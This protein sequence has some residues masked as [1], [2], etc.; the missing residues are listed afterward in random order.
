MGLPDKNESQQNWALFL[1]RDGVINERLAGDY[2]KDILQFRFIDGALEALSFLS[3]I[4]QKI[5]I[6]SNQ[7]GIGKGIMT[8]RE[9]E[10]VHLFM[11]EKIN[12]SGGRIDAIYYCPALES[13]NHPDRK[14]GI[15]MAMKAQQDFTEIE[16]SKSYMVGDSMSD[17]DFG[18]AL[19]MK[20][21]FVNGSESDIKKSKADLFF[22]SLAEFA[23]YVEIYKNSL[24]L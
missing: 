15:G 11:V 8:E 9:L 10:T 22:S 3:K 6:V 18:K 21:V 13:D 19:A 24:F 1:D 4:F 17:I 20:T 16:F 7:Q 23:K 5:I 14:P 12:H 2:V